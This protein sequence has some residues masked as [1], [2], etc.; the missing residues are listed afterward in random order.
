M[1]LSKRELDKGQGTRAGCCRS[2]NAKDRAGRETV[3]K[4][5]VKQRYTRQ[6]QGTRETRQGSRKVRCLLQDGD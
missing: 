2:C 4:D 3:D 1:S 5:R 6:E